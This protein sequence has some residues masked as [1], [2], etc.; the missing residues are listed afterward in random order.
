MI[1]FNLLPDIKLEYMR[2]KRTKRIV[3]VTSV[4][5]SS[6]A[7]LIFVSL[8][9]A[10]GIFQKTHMNN[11]SDDIVKLSK[12]LNDT[13]DLNKILTVQ[14]QLN[15]LVGVHQQ[16]PAVTRVFPFIQQMTPE[17]ANIISLN[18]GF[19][20][21]TMVINGTADSLITV[22]KFV[23]TLKF[24]DYKEG[25]NSEKAFSEVVL[26]SFAKTDKGATYTI[27]LKYNPVI[28]DNTKSV[29]LDVPNIV[30][31]RSETE[32]PT[33]LFELNTTQEQGQ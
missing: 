21:G 17:A 2:T 7:L 11:L 27:S 5:I 1:Q 20:E 6:A 3:M 26:T 19:G 23:D 29:S 32:K 15:S 4:A 10:V 30:T 22:N 8:L 13:P 16:K 28:F 12:D 9:M 25:S 33:S 18:V 14:N 31:T 24:T